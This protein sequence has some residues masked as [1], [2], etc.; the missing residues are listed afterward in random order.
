MS[1]LIERRAAP[2]LLGQRGSA[3]AGSSRHAGSA[4]LD[5]MHEGFYMLFMLK[6]GSAPGDEQSFMDRITAFLDD[7]EREAKKS[8]PM[9]TISRRPSMRSVRPSMKS[10][11][12]RLSPCAN[13][14]SGA[15]CS[16]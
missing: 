6:H 12:P 2:S 15:R 8:A 16:C 3:P 11:W 10:S 7:F 14:G 9:A 4:L 5:L 1:Q 13:S